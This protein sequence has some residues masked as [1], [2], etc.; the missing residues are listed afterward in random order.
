[1]GCAGDVGVQFCA[2]PGP[3]ANYAIDV[4]PANVGHP[5]AAFPVA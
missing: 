4:T 2:D 1:M 3:C 5:S